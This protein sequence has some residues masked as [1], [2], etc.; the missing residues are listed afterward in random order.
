[1]TER[2]L[3]LRVAYHYLG[4]P[5]RWGGDDPSG[6]D[7]SGLMIE[8]LKSCGRF[9]RI[10]DTTADGLMRMYERV[11]HPRPADLVFWLRAERAIHVGML[12]EDPRFYI[13]ADGGGSRT[14][15]EDDAWKQNA[16]VQIRPVESRG[17]PAERVFA[18]PF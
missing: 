6:F 13:G 14:R 11:T 2:E 18:S 16:Y 1:M 3:A 12:I 17:S 8:A 15:S 4:T 7:C 9:A 5:Y 10:G